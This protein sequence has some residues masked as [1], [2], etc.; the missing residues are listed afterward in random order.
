[1]DVVHNLSVPGFNSRI[2]EQDVQTTQLSLLLFDIKTMTAS[3]SPGMRELFSLSEHE[4]SADT[5]TDLV[6]KDDREKV[7]AS[8]LEMLETGYVKRQY[9]SYTRT[10]KLIWIHSENWVIYDDNKEP[11]QIVNHVFDISEI[12]YNE[13]ALATSVSLHN[14]LMNKCMDAIWR[15]ELSKP[16]PL[17]LPQPAQIEHLLDY[18]I[19][20]E[21]NP[22]YAASIG[23]PDID[24]SGSSIGEISKDLDGARAILAQFTA[25]GY[26]FGGAEISHENWGLH[27]V[28]KTLR[29]WTTPVIENNMLLG[30]WGMHTDLTEQKRHEKII[31]EIS[32]GL[33]AE[34]GNAFFDALT[35][36][37][38]E[39][40]G[41][42]AAYLSQILPGQ[43]TVCISN[44]YDAVQ[45]YYQPSPTP[46]QSQHFKRLETE[47]MTDNI[48]ISLDHDNC[49][50]S[51]QFLS[52]L[53]AES[54]AQC[55]LNDNQGKTLGYLTLLFKKN[56]DDT[57]ELK[58]ML[59][60]FSTRAAA[61]LIRSKHELALNNS[62]Q[63]LHYLANHDSL[64]GLSNR[65]H[66]TQGLEEM[67]ARQAKNKGKVG[68]LL[69]DLD[70]FKEVNDTLG[71]QMGDALLV[72]LAKRLA[73]TKIAKN[74]IIS[75][76]G[77]DEFAL[78]VEDTSEEELD[79]IANTLMSKVRNTIE[80]S[81]IQLQLNG[82]LGIAV[83]P[84]TATT[85]VKLMSCADVAMYHAKNNDKQIQFYE[86]GID[87]YSR[88]RLALMS[89]LKTAVNNNEM[90]LVYQPLIDV[91]SNQTCGF[92]A[93][94][95]WHHPKYG[96]VMPLDFIPL[97]EL[98]EA[99]H[100]IT[101]WVV[102]T[103]AMQII[104]WQ[105]AGYDYV[106]SLNLSA[107]NLMDAELT[108]RV[109]NI[110]QQSGLK[111]S[112]LEL[113]I[114][115]SALM[116]DIERA[117]GVIEK[118]NALGVNSVIDDYGT[119]YSS[120][121]YLQRLP[122]KKIKI[123]RTFVS[124]MVNNP[125]DKIIV[126]STI[127][128]AHNLGKQVVAEGIEDQAT[129]DALKQ[130]GCDIAQGYF[131]SQPMSAEYWAEYHQLKRDVS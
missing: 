33:S 35:K 117:T 4:A 20:A 126:Q 50:D 128:L 75:R 32:Q 47:V 87:Q 7:I 3:I 116:S 51:E 124:N 106:V 6:H 130:L 19:F 82:S 40:L 55:I 16:M 95:R 86:A 92:E 125:Q 91:K 42:S 26:E 1:M 110:I 101:E 108:N 64:T 65:H 62:K 43:N 23:M 70:G 121:A 28:N 11:S 113:E 63:E 78:A 93:L 81:N 60:I 13:E 25:L 90:A 54:Y 53:E 57:A 45:K 41:A 120:L 79:T 69:L 15:I 14:L 59:N 122:I 49:D 102:K 34:T 72:T 115:E 39:V 5:L 74:S 31:Y 18:A 58:K 104:H 98:S 56:I 114:T 68:L 29:M 80:L 73:N 52:E 37:I 100:E 99:I 17:D 21:H 119:G 118:F 105:A 77:G 129:L 67:I 36:Y 123:D 76:L 107:K 111:P 131:F 9:R 2:I 10:G 127:Q 103:V 30:F 48:Y 109:A 96:L 24:L 112:N 88:K 66:F 83:F 61:E 89:D 12:K 71:H 84:D 44:G 85:A 27:Q 94:I 46:E 97:A 8:T 38:V 22:A